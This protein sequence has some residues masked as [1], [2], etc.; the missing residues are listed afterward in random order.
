[1]ND[2]EAK[3]T[4]KEYIALLEDHFAENITKSI[5]QEGQISTLQV[6][7]KSIESKAATIEGKVTAIKVLVRAAK[8]E[9]PQAIVRYKASVEFEDKVNEVICD[10]FYKDFDEC[11]RKVA[12]AFH[13]LDLKD[14]ITN[15]PK[16]IKGGADAVA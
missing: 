1:M 11:K 14:I 3:I 12:Q 10:A 7:L 15:E 16:E 13:L 4:K 2:H 8:E 5:H 6:R 9:V